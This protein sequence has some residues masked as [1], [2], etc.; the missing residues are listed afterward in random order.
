[1][2]FKFQIIKKKKKNFFFFLLKILF[3]QQKAVYN[4]VELVELVILLKKFDL[5]NEHI[6]NIKCYLTL[7]I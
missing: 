4:L 5:R 3:F 6:N 7:N 1:M 2:N